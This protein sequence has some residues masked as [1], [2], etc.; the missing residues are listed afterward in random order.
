MDILAQVTKGSLF[1]KLRDAAD[2]FFQ[3]KWIS[4]WFCRPVCIRHG[5]LRGPVSWKKPG[6]DWP[7]GADRACC[8]DAV[9]PPKLCTM[10]NWGVI[11][12]LR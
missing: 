12:F 8:G 6:P 5:E 2:H 9:V 3:R 4:A 1:Q 7:A 11:L 10:D